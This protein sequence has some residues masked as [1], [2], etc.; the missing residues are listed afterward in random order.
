MDALPISANGG[1]TGRYQSTRDLVRQS[2]Y[3]KVITGF[4]GAKDVEEKPPT[5]EK[6]LIDTLPPVATITARAPEK[7]DAAHDDDPKLGVSLDVKL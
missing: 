4:L 3:K 2:V 6:S 5:A 7:S 1:A